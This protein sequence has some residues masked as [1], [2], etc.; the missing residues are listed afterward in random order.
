MSDWKEALDNTRTGSF[1]PFTIVAGCSRDKATERIQHTH[2]RRQIF[3][4]PLCYC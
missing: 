3:L 1:V 4:E 2:Q